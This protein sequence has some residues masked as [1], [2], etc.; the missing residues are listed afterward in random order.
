M[1]MSCG[2]FVNE[3]DLRRSPVHIEEIETLSLSPKEKNDLRVKYRNNLMNNGKKKETKTTTTKKKKK[4]KRSTNEREQC[5]ECNKEE[6]LKSFD[7]HRP[8]VKLSTSSNSSST[9]PT[10]PQ[11]HQE[12]MSNNLPPVTA[13]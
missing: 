11:I 4:R 5:R 3:I 13:E 7:F 10:M 2:D 6:D 12:A 8:I 9:S 1:T